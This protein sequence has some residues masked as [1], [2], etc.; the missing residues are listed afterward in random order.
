MVLKRSPTWTRMA[1]LLL[2]AAL[3]ACDIAPTAMPASGTATEITKAI[4]G[5]QYTGL[6][7]WSK[8]AKDPRL[9]LPLFASYTVAA[10]WRSIARQAAKRGVTLRVAHLDPNTGGEFRGSWGGGEIVINDLVLSEPIDV[11]G[12]VIAHEV[13]HASHTTPSGPVAC[14]EEEAQAFAWGALAYASIVRTDPHEDD[15]TRG[16]ERVVELWKQG[17]TREAVL[18]HDGYQRECLGGV[19]Q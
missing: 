10:Q 17:R 8:L 1:L 15:W 5:A 7:D 18:L 6:A 4:N 11:Q 9:E 14:L 2:I 3:T 12:Y 16:A 13:F 19:V